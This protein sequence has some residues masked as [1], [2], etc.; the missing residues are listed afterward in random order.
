MRGFLPPLFWPVGISRFI[1][2]RAC[3]RLTHIRR[4][5]HALFH[6]LR[7]HLSETGTARSAVESSV[8]ATSLLTGIN[9]AWPAI[10]PIVKLDH[11]LQAAEGKAR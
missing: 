8:Q 7:E 3:G 6:A 11:S 10:R 9:P 2:A 5:R 4:M 1:P